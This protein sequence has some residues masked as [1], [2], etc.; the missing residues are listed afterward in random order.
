[1]QRD[2]RSWLSV[3]VTIEPS[4]FYLSMGFIREIWD[5]S[6]FICASAIGTVGP[7]RETDPV[8]FACEISRIISS[9]GVWP[10]QKT[11]SAFHSTNEHRYW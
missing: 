6:C 5:Y 9:S 8:T 2:L 11:N 4:H 1:M 3:H 10:T 7:I